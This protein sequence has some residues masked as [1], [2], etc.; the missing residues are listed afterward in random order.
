MISSLKFCK[1]FTISRIQDTVL[2][3]V[4]QLS[5]EYCLS[6]VHRFQVRSLSRAWKSWLETCSVRN[7]N[8]TMITRHC[9]HLKSRWLQS[10][11]QL[12]VQSITKRE[13]FFSPR[14]YNAYYIWTSRKYYHFSICCCLLLQIICCNVI[15]GLQLWRHIPFLLLLNS[16]NSGCVII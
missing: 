3:K 10:L 16:T 14:P 12:V 7:N 9:W 13:A 15:Y 4:V 5:A 1:N 2:L 6:I 11:L 8:I